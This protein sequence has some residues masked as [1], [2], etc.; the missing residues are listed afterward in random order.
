MNSLKSMT[1]V[2]Q[3]KSTSTDFDFKHF[4][5]KGQYISVFDFCQMFNYP[6]QIV[7]A[8]IT[9]GF[10]LDQIDQNWK[11]WEMF[12]I[13]DEWKTRND[14]LIHA[15]QLPRITE[16]HSPSTSIIQFNSEEVS[17]SSEK[18]KIKKIMAKPVDPKK[19]YLYY[20]LQNYQPRVS[21]TEDF[22]IEL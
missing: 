6:V 5:Y 18:D 13:I 2:F 11:R 4:S 17:P 20:F 16:N 19:T 7:E 14:T 12:G 1:M 9:D 22:N 8:M 3:P 21:D 15:L 10:S